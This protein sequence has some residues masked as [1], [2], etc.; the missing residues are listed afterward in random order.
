M[1]LLFVAYYFDPFPGVGAKRISYW[2]RQIHAQFPHIRC[3]VITATDPAGMTFPTIDH[4]HH[5]PDLGKTTWAFQKRLQGYSWRRDLVRFIRSRPAEYDAC[6]MTGGP[7]MPFGVAP[8][9][10]RQ[11]GCRILLDFR[12]PFSNNPVHPMAGWKRGLLRRLEKRY[13][14]NA[15]AVIVVNH[16]C[17]K[18]LCECRAPVY[19]IENGYDEIILDPLRSPLPHGEKLR[20]VYAGKLLK[21]R[22]PGAFLDVIQRPSFRADISF[23]HIGDPHPAVLAAQEKSQNIHSAGPMDYAGALQGMMACDV[24]VLFTRGEP[25]ESTSKIFDYIGLEKPILIITG[26]EPRTGELHDI[27]RDYPAVTWCRNNSDE[28][29]LALETLGSA[30]RP[31]HYPGREQHARRRGLSQLVDA[32]TECIEK[33]PGFCERAR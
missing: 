17:R 13:I 6:V 32:L 2:A 30:R 23:T 18:L 7:F 14:Q 25:F 33:V 24:G 11:Y 21:H 1:K 31:V 8:L 12:D 3:D 28:I 5:V 10:R 4:L 22:D 29:A 9:I 15:D 16:H 27:T 19:I 20:L 26:G